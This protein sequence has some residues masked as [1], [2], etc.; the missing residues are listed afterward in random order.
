[1]IF[2][3]SGTGNSRWAAQE[4]EQKTGEPI[5][6]IAEALQTNCHFTLNRGESIGF[7]F[8]VHGWRVPKIVVEFMQSLSLSEADKHATEEHYAFC[9]LTTG[10]STG[11]TMERFVKLLGKIKSKNPIKLHA[12]ASVLMPES[13]VGLPG[14]DIDTAE[15]EQEKI[16]TAKKRIAHFASIINNKERKVGKHPIG[17][18]SIH[19]GTCPDILSGPIGAFFTHWLITD[20]PFRVERAK[21]VKCGICANVCPVNDIAGG[22]GNE[23]QWLNNGKC[24][25]CFSCYHHCPHHAIE[26]GNRTKNKGQY[27]FG[28]RKL[29]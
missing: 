3:F 2:Y 14:M 4:L 5:V 1:M 16:A 9:L 17:W 15:K 6:S 18:E 28:R 10:D 21:C 13:Y 26:Y 19:R 22:L 29:R 11:R 8:P 25:T 24:L 27:F 23:P 7:V 20:K 12:V